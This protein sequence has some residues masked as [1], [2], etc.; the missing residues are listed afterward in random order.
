M[1]WTNPKRKERRKRLE[2]DRMTKMTKTIR[3]KKI[4]M[5]TKWLLRMGD[6]KAAPVLALGRRVKRQLVPILE[7]LPQTTL[8]LPH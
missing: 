7:L 8:H 3:W 4:R 5:M 6:R 2:L 1:K